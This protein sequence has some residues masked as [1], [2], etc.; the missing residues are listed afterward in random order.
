MEF[1]LSPN[2]TYEKLE[3]N[4][5]EDFIDVFEDRML[6]WIFKPVEMLLNLEEGY[7]AAMGILSTYFEA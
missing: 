1:K 5:L 4:D 2:Y 6:N 3:S 7:I